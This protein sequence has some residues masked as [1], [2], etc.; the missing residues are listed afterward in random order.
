MF[1]GTAFRAW[2]LA[3]QGQPEEGVAKLQVMVED[4]MAAG[5]EESIFWLSTL[6]A[7][8]HRTSGRFQEAI[9]LAGEMLARNQKRGWK[10]GFNHLQLQQVQGDLMLMDVSTASKAEL[11]FRQVIEVARRQDAKL[12]ELRATNSLAR[13]LSKQ[14]RRDEARAM[15]A[16]IYNWFTEG[17]DTVDLKDAKA[18][19]DE[20]NR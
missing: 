6:L 3:A 15:V 12:F 11:C 1:F 10:D 18:L 17:F 9:E 8:C 19:L 7:E 4:A 2:A 13:L 16:D 14:G 5:W 20:L